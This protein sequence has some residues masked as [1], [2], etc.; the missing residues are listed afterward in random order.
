MTDPDDGDPIERK[1]Q[2]A[3][4]STF[5]V[6]IPREWG[7]SQD[8]E[9]GETIYLYRHRDRLVIAPS[10]IEASEH[11]A[12]VDA[13][14]VELEALQQQVRAAYTAGCNQ[15]SIV[16]D[17]EI[18]DEVRRRTHQTVN[19]LVG[20]GVRKEESDRIVVR[21]HLDTRAVSPEQSLVQ[22]RQLALGMQ[23]DAMEAVRM[24]DEMLAHRVVERDDHVDRLFAF[25]SRGLHRGLEDVNE[26]DRLDVDR[27]TVFYY[28]KIARELERIADRGERVA[29]VVEKQSSPP[30]K[31]LGTD[32]AKTVEGAIE[33]VELALND[34][35]DEAVETYVGVFDRIDAL[36]EDLSRRS[37][38]DA[39]LYGTIVESARR[40]AQRGI[41]VVNASIETSVNELVYSWTD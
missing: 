33:V 39:Y 41:N 3:G 16:T 30:D 38:P 2:L 35:P 31:G 14:D 22:I 17:E 25:I 5:T 21:D 40:T 37:D 23:S 24:N 26:L 34:D 4:G 8:I 6:S 28:Y 10:K 13:D 20:M 18:P 12:R 32:L 1:V 27:E 36:D 7:V 11:T 9:K 15:I 19:T 29:G